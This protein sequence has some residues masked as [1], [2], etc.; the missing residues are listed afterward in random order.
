MLAP[1]HGALKISSASAIG[2]PGQTQALIVDR[3]LLPM[4]NTTVVQSANSRRIFTT[5]GTSFL[6]LKAF[7]WL[8]SQW[9]L[10]YAPCMRS[11]SRLGMSLRFLVESLDYPGRS[12]L[13]QLAL[14]ATFVT[15]RVPIQP[16]HFR[17]GLATDF[18]PK[19]PSPLSFY[20]QETLILTARF[21]GPW[22]RQHNHK[23]H[24]RPTLS[25][26]ENTP[27]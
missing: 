21:C 24:P 4:E 13:T 17:E 18:T 25:V 8:L 19:R 27:A 14:F 22:S 12:G 23:Y 5:F 2:A 11:L 7:A 20:A 10:S 16:F 9:S 15:H 3:S 26:S 6:R 1:N